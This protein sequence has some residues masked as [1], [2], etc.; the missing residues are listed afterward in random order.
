MSAFQTPEING[1]L[2]ELE[3]LLTQCRVALLMG[4]GCSKCAGLPLMD[5]LTTIVQKKLTASSLDV[6]NAV[7][8]GFTG[9]PRCTIEDF[10]SE[11]VDLVAIAERRKLRNATSPT[12]DIAGK[13]FTSDTLGTALDDVKREI[14]KACHRALK[15]SQLGANENQPY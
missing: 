9:S 5:E 15:T 14:A 8:K 1:Y 3:N 7:L 2:Q 6:L 10:M 11:I 12:V 4:A 13:T